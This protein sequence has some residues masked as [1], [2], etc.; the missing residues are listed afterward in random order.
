MIDMAVIVA[1][2]AGIPCGAFFVILIMALM[3]TASD[4]D[5]EDEY[6]AEI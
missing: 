1:F 5:Q 4:R 2:L 6:D 3:F